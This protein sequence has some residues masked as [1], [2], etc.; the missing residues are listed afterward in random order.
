[1]TAQSPTD[2]TKHPPCYFGG[3]LCYKESA[4]LEW[5]MQISA[6]AEPGSDRQS[7]AST[8]TADTVC[9]TTDEQF[10]ISLGNILEPKLY[11]DGCRRTTQPEPILC[12]P[13]LTATVL[14]NASCKRRSLVTRPR[15]KS[16]DEA[17]PTEKSKALLRQDTSQKD[18]NSIKVKDEANEKPALKQGTNTDGLPVDERA[19]RLRTRLQT[20]AL[21]RREASLGSLVVVQ[22]PALNGERDE[23]CIRTYKSPLTRT[24]SSLKIGEE[25]DILDRVAVIKVEKAFL[26]EEARFCKVWKLKNGRVFGIFLTRQ[27]SSENNWGVPERIREVIAVNGPEES[28]GSHQ[29]FEML[30][31]TADDEYCENVVEYRDVAYEEQ[32]QVIAKKRCRIFVV[33]MTCHVFLLLVAAFIFLNWYLSCGLFGSQVRQ[34]SEDAAVVAIP[35]VECSENPLFESVKVRPAATGGKV[36]KILAASGVLGGLGAIGATQT[37]TRVSRSIESTGAGQTTSVTTALTSLEAFQEKL[38]GSLEAALMHEKLTPSDKSG[39]AMHLINPSWENVEETLWDCLR[40]P[41]EA[42]VKKLAACIRIVDY[43]EKWNKHYRESLKSLCLDVVDAQVSEPQVLHEEGPLYEGLAPMYASLVYLWPGFAEKLSNSSPHDTAIVRMKELAADWLERV[44]RGPG[45]IYK[46]PTSQIQQ[47]DGDD[48]KELTRQVLERCQKHGRTCH[49]FPGESLSDGKVTPERCPPSRA[50][51]DISLLQL[52]HQLKA[53]QRLEQHQ[54]DVVIA[55]IK[56]K[57]THWLG[58]AEGALVV[59]PW[60]LIPQEMLASWL[61]LAATT[62]PEEIISKKMF[63]VLNTQRNQPESL[64]V[65]VIKALNKSSYFDLSDCSLHF[66]FDDD[67]IGVYDDEFKRSSL[68]NFLD[69]SILLIDRE[70]DWSRWSSGQ[71]GGNIWM[72]LG[73]LMQWKRPG[74]YKLILDFRLVKQFSSPEVVFPGDK[75]PD[76]EASLKLLSGQVEPQFTSKYVH[77]LNAFAGALGSDNSYEKVSELQLLLNNDDSKTGF[78]APRLRECPSRDGYPVVD[79]KPLQDYCL[80][81]EVY[82]SPQRK[83]LIKVLHALGSPHRKRWDSLVIDLSGLASVFEDMPAAYVQDFVRT[84]KKPKGPRDVKIW[85]E[86]AVERSAASVLGSLVTVGGALSSDSLTAY[87]HP[88]LFLRV[89]NAVLNQLTKPEEKYVDSELI[90]F[91]LGDIPHSKLL[92]DAFLWGTPPVIRKRIDQESPLQLVKNSVGPTFDLVQGLSLAQRVIC[93]KAMPC[94]PNTDLWSDVPWKEEVWKQAACWGDLIDSSNTNDDSSDEGVCL[95]D[96]SVTDP[97]YDKQDFLTKAHNA[98]AEDG[99]N[100]WVAVMLTFNSRKNGP[101]VVSTHVPANVFESLMPMREYEEEK[102][103]VLDLEHSKKLLNAMKEDAKRI[104]GNFGGSTT[105]RVNARP[106]DTLRKQ[107]SVE[108]SNHMMRVIKDSNVASGSKVIS[109]LRLS[110]PRSEDEHQ[111]FKRLAAGLAC[112]LRM[113]STIQPSILGESHFC[114]AVISLMRDACG[115]KVWEDTNVREDEKINDAW[116]STLEIKFE[117]VDRNSRRDLMQIYQQLFGS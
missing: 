109:T 107:Y 28:G 57:L 38:D 42:I 55:Q 22:Q 49:E 37:K 84:R 47:L 27:S 19:G 83:T 7:N 4:N 86:W 100:R 52:V 20:E 50:V 60:M 56:S 35:G 110:R 117:K 9:D 63:S 1:M 99:W 76:D 92:A 41:I 46:D 72:H 68:P 112:G 75:W 74:R 3:L 105:F 104:A 32:M 67:W 66:I 10:S 111:R 64:L 14:Q 36:G 54:I 51:L 89:D 91:L 34:R 93:T 30:E 44:L 6:F 59:R 48:L 53:F 79:S 62:E 40:V 29:I 97:L 101:S 81:I 115:T 12:D 71:E 8:D 15:S 98:L 87:S 80:D 21:Q 108:G 39:R 106:W 113:D 13:D 17:N 43:S 95:F 96:R 77:I 102:T 11:R 78:S 16:D 26:K 31:V 94:Y 103:R 23:L 85:R 82:G 70:V 69:P 65:A 25:M 114:G 73:K 33:L 61:R 18:S 5:Q 58:N 2:G 24:K 116:K 88:S 90:P 45:S